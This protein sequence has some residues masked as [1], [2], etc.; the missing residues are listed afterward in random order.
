MELWVVRSLNNG[1][2]GWNA[3]RVGYGAWMFTDAAQECPIWQYGN[4]GK[5]R[6]HVSECA[7][8]CVFAGELGFVLA[9]ILFLRDNVSTWFP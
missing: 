9:L 4:A 1:W 7:C 3:W 2:G 6:V 8:V 5:G